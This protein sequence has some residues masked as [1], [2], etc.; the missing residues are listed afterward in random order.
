MCKYLCVQL[1][2]FLLV[3]KPSSSLSGTLDYGGKTNLHLPREVT[4]DKQFHPRKQGLL[5]LNIHPP[6][7]SKVGPSSDKD[8]ATT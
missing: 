1:L 6:T 5:P 4:E 3:S 7:R 2:S 8:K